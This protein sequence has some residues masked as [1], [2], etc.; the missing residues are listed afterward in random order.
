MADD[1]FLKNNF[2]VTP[3]SQQIPIQIAGSSTYGRYD[4]IASG[5][6][7]NMF[8]SEGWLVNFAGYKKLVQL[9]AQGES[10]RG[11]FKS[12]RGNFVIAVCGSLVYKITPAFAANQ[13]LGNLETSSGEVFMDE[14][15]NSQVCIVDGLNAY[16]YNYSTNS[17]IVKQTGGPLATTLV[18]NHVSFHNTFFNIGNAVQDGNGARWF[19]FGYTSATVISEISN[20]TIST[21]P[22][23]ALAVERLPGQSNNVIVFGKTVC[24]IWTAIGGLQNY[25]RNSSVN[26]DYGCA[27]INTI[28]VSDQ[29]VAWLAANE[30]N[31]PVIMIFSGEGAQRISSDGID[32][33]LSKIKKPSDSTAFF[34]RQDGHLFY[35]LTFYGDGD[36]LTLIYDLNTQ[37]FFNLTDYNSDFHPARDV[38][39]FNNKM[40]FASLKNGY[41]YETSSTITVYNENLSSNRVVWDPLAIHEIPRIRVCESIRRPDSGRFITNSFV[42]TMAQGDDPNVTGLSLNSSYEQNMITE[43]TGDTMITEDGQLMITENSLPNTGSGMGG[44]PQNLTYQPRVDMSFSKDSGVTWSNYVGRGLNP[45][46]VRQN[47]ITWGNLGRSNDMTIKLRFWGLSSFVV[48]DGIVEVY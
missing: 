13:L 12:T 41:L 20:Q 14:N 36:H 33:V 29:Y 42:F 18:P 27:S 21:K 22:D 8:I 11:M 25:R 24:E 3:G 7:F 46:G 16:I 15:L 44:N 39:Y 4:K 28:A 45:I 19:T 43:D 9:N 26:I 32:F 30:D 2:R 10:V 17:A 1:T 38:V 47:I 5:L 34:F 37:K 40:I 31:Q 48:T 6:T 23:S 35:Q